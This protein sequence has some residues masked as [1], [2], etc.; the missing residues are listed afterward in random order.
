EMAE[1]IQPS[2]VP[3]LFVLATGA[4][5]PNP[6]E[7]LTAPGF[8]DVLDQLRD[9]FDFVLIDTPP[10][11]AVTDPAAVAPRVDGVLLVVRISNAGGRQNAKRAVEMLSALG[12]K[13]LDVVVNGVNPTR[14]Y[15]SYAYHS[16]GYEATESLS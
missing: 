16:Y 1:A 8:K 13:V 15:G 10:L 14:R 12:T 5:P 3:G 7:I 6:A 4:I 11:L 2:I 9:E